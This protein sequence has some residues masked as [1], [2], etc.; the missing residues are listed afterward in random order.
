MQVKVC[1]FS[2]E[3]FA[4]LLLQYGQLIILYTCLIQGSKSARAVLADMDPWGSESARTPVLGLLV[5]F[6]CDDMSSCLSGAFPTVMEKQLVVVFIDG[7]FRQHQ[8]GT[9]RYIDT[10]FS[11][12]FQW[13]NK[14]KIDQLYVHLPRLPSTHQFFGCRCFFHFSCVHGL[15]SLF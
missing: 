14:I 2:Q 10:S 7:F 1:I 13:Y 8:K 9:S 15:R 12:V 4:C 3:Y 5:A 11:T 6:D